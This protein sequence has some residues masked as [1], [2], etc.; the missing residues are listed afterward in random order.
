MVAYFFSWQSFDCVK[1]YMSLRGSIPL[2]YSR[3]TNLHHFSLRTFPFFCLKKM[4]RQITIRITVYQY[5][6]LFALTLFFI[7]HGIVGNEYLRGN[8]NHLFCDSTSNF[9][10][11]H[12]NFSDL[13]YLKFSGYVTCDCDNSD[14]I[15]F[16]Y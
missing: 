15:G 10:T 14:R 7:G 2:E 8:V 16:C 9:T 4:H 13:D 1:D 6:L 3:L 12:S 5:C 11:I